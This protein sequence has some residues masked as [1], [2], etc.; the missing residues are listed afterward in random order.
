MFWIAARAS[1]VNSDSSNEC[2]SA[3][4]AVNG[5]SKRCSSSPN[6]R[7]SSPGAPDFFGQRPQHAGQPRHVG[8]RQLRHRCPRRCRTLRVVQQ[9]DHG[10]P[11]DCRRDKANSSATNAVA[12]AASTGMTSP[13]A[14]P[15][16]GAAKGGAVQCSFC[17]CSCP[18]WIRHG[19]LRRRSPRFDYIRRKRRL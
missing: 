18:P 2:R 15:E 17:G 14:S 3:L 16:S 6:A 13:I 5:I 7:P 10:S 19:P 4:L 9:T 12:E 8:Q 11:P 1:R